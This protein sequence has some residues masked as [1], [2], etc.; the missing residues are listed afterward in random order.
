MLNCF[1]SLSSYVTENIVRIHYK[2][3]L[4]HAHL[5]LQHQLVRHREYGP[6]QI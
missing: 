4:I 5:F 6:Y 3:C 1:F 2:I